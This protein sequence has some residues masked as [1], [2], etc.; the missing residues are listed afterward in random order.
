MIC[1]YIDN[2]QQIDIEHTTKKTA[3]FDAV[4]C[5]KTVF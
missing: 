3:S 1:F 5:I 4:S 2:L